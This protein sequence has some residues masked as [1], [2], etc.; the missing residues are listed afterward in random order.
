M[1]IRIINLNI[2]DVSTTFKCEEY[3]SGIKILSETQIITEHEHG[4]IRVW[5]LLTQ[6]NF[7]LGNS[8]NDF[9]IQNITVITQN[10]ILLHFSWGI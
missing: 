2:E 3:I 1:Q 8:Y 4:R 10:I 7:I 9:W 5:D 6:S